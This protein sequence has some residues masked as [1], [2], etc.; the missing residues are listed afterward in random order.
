MDSHL[1]REDMVR[2]FSQDALPMF[3]VSLSDPT[4]CSQ[5]LIRMA[6]IRA[7]DPRSR[8][9]YLLAYDFCCVLFVFV[10]LVLTGARTQPHA[11][12]LRARTDETG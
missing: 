6:L 12:S 3:R 10:L 9:S 1:H 4:H 5:H 8:A 2:T 11:S 7:Y